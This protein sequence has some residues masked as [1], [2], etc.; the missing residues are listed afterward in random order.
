VATV[1]VQKGTLK[2]GDIVV[3]GAEWGR[4]RA[5]LDDKGRQ[6]KD[7]LQDKSMAAWVAMRGEACRGLLVG[8]TMPAPWFAGIV[9]TDLAFAA[10]ARGDELLRQFVAWCRLRRVRRIDMGVSAGNDPRIAAVYR[11]AGFEHSGAMF[12]MNLEVPR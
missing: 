11:R 6:L 12:H 3:A 4:V 1:L 5:M 7:A 10:D 2:Q 9:A 8:M